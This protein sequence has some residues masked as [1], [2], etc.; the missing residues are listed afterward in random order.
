MERSSGRAKVR[1]LIADDQPW[2]RAAL[3]RLIRQQS[4]V[5]LLGAARDAEELLR[6]ARTTSPDVVLTDLRMPGNVPAAI[7]TLDRARDRPAV[8]VLS[9]YDEIAALHTCIE[10]GATA[11]L[12]K[13]LSPQQILDSIRDHAMWRRSLLDAGSWAKEELASH[14]RVR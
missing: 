2:V 7:R 1:V 12:L 4:D 10:A 6:L 5:V 8:I 9:A 3:T 14:S 11:Y 13:D